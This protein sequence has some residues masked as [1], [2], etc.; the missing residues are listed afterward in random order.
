ML[1]SLRGQDSGLTHLAEKK[2]KIGKQSPPS[3][4]TAAYTAGKY[5]PM[6]S[7]SWSGIWSTGKRGAERFRRYKA[8]FGAIGR[9]RFSSL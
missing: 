2:Q 1:G 4:S 6:G 9:L 7:A 5:L 8:S 3:A